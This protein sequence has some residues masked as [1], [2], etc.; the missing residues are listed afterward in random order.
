VLIAVIPPLLILGAVWYESNAYNQ[1]WR[2]STVTQQINTFSFLLAQREDNITQLLKVNAAAFDWPRLAVASPKRTRVLTPGESIGAG[3]DYLELIDTSG[4]VFWSRSRPELIGDKIVIPRDSIKSP[5]PY[6][7]QIEIDHDGRHAALSTWH[8]VDSTLRLYGGTYLDNQFLSLLV[9]LVDATVD[10]HYFDADSANQELSRMKPRE[11]YEQDG[12][13]LTILMGG[14]ESGF[15]LSATYSPQ[16]RLPQFLT[17]YIVA[18]VVGVFAIG[19]AV[20][21]AWSLARRADLELN[22]LLAATERVA[23]GDLETPLFAYDT[24]EFSRLADGLSDMIAKLKKSQERLSATE[25]I[26]AWQVMGRKIAHEIKNPLTPISIS[27]DDLRRSYSEGRTDF[28]NTLT[29]CTTTIKNEIARMTRLL[30]QFVAF[31][32]MPAPSPTAVDVI[33]IVEDIRSLFQADI[34]AGRLE[35]ANRSSRKSVFVDPEQIKQLLIN[36]IKNGQE[37]SGGLVTVRIADSEKAIV[38]VVEDSGPGFSKEKLANPFE[39]YVS[40]KKEG[41]GLGLVICQRI[42][43]DHGGAIELYNRTEGGAGVRVTLPQS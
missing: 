3:L 40:T 8:D 5:T 35:V 22:N 34:T 1:R 43:I 33:S 25:R 37:A 18:I 19:F 16:Q 41:S 11:L 31:A 23:R 2:Q 24:G 29:E 4:K 42:A 32:R 15:F 17:L 38:I 39:P 10:L 21:L 36:L 30:D 6:L 12:D 13:L 7:T 27:T 20:A 9:T 14:T 28:G 26:A